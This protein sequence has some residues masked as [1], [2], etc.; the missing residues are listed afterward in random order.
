MNSGASLFFGI[1][2]AILTTIGVYAG[3]IIATGLAMSI[4]DYIAGLFSAII[5]KKRESEFDGCSMIGCLV[6][7]YIPLSL[8][9][10]YKILSLF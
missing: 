4:F 3:L 9:I 6:V 2:F 1:A 10:A 8:F 7:I 5:G